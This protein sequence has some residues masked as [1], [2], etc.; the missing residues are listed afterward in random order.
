MLIGRNRRQ[1]VTKVTTDKGRKVIGK[2]GLGK[3]SVFGI[4]DVIEVIS[5]KNGLKN[6][7]KMDLL[8]IKTSKDSS[9]NPEIIEHDLK[10][11]EPSGTVLKLKKN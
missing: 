3:L 2:K 5:I 11:Q 7:F 1:G 8:E 10:T 6:H 4:C 9:Y